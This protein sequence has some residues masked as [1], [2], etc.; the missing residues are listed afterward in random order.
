[1]GTPVGASPRVSRCPLLSG[2]AQDSQG[3]A[4]RPAIWPRPSE[5]EPM[6]LAAMSREPLRSLLPLLP[7]A[8][9]HR[10]EAAG[11]LAGAPGRPGAAVTTGFRGV[12]RAPRPCVLAIRNG[13]RTRGASLDAS[14]EGRG[15]EGNQLFATGIRERL[16]AEHVIHDREPREL[17]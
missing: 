15:Q 5:E 11:G 3:I 4:E 12:V 1:S 7:E 10:A 9:A 13:S 16:G 2:H 6:S 8:D 17:G 14:G